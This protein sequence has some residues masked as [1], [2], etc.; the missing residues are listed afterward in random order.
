MNPPTVNPSGNHQ[1]LKSH[2]RFEN[3]GDRY[4]FCIPAS[5]Q[6]SYSVHPRP[7]SARFEKADPYG[8]DAYPCFGTPLMP[9]LLQ[10]SL[11]VETTPGLHHGRI[12]IVGRNP[13]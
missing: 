6:L 5:P 11:H 4:R 2:K 10:G 1:L 7:S 13:G 8:A 12:F 9:F 3:V